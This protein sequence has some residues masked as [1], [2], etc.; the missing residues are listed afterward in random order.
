MDLV[1]LPDVEQVLS[2][3]L[4]SLTE[5]TDLV[6]QRVWTQLPGLKAGQEEWRFPCV[7]LVRIGGRPVL[8]RPLYIDRPL[9]QFDI[10]GGPKVEARTI[11]ETC[12]AALAQAHT[13]AHDG[14]VIS[15][16]ELG[17][18]AFLPDDD[19]LPPKPRYT[20]DAAVTLHPGPTTGS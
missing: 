18:L 5:I 3:F 19:F 2:M 17:A 13:V 7:R 20:F 15:D 16:A 9:L 8:Q 1:L 4:R 10:W 14:A 12:R 6:D 11:A